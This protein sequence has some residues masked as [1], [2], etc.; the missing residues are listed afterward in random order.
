TIFPST[1]SPPLCACMAAILAS[2]ALICSCRALISA[3]SL[4]SSA[5][6]RSRSD[7]ASAAPFAL[8]SSTLSWSRA[9][10]SS[11]SSPFVW[12]RAGLGSSAS[13]NRASPP[14]APAH[15]ARKVVTHGLIVN[16]PEYNTSGHGIGSTRTRPALALR[17]HG[18]EV[19]GPLPRP[20]LHLLAE[21]FDL[22]QELLE[23][24]FEVLDPGVL[25][26]LEAG[27]RR[28]LRR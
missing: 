23:L 8:S 19:G 15:V 28:R 11:S 24:P 3:C 26:R 17:R 13:A 16:S 9:R 27:I 10:F 18:G 2:R 1:R 21:H 5:R 7:C 20:R 12:A 22:H 25:L 6:A 14:R 4:A